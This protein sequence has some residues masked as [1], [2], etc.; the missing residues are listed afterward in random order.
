MGKTQGKSLENITDKKIM[1]FKSIDE[2]MEFW[3]THDATEFEE[4]EVTVEEIIDELRKNPKNTQVTIR[5]ETEL[6]INSKF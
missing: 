6:Q 3:D 5:L 4:K 1:E 2:E